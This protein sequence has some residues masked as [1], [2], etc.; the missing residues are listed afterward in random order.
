MLQNW[1]DRPLGNSPGTTSRL[2]RRAPL[3]QVMVR[4]FAPIHARRRQKEL[5]EA[6]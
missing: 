6:A 4:A 5:A 1:E 3:S 2:A